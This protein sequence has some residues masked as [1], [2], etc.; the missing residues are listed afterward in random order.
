MYYYNQKGEKAK[1]IKNKFVNQ[2]NKPIDGLT[3]NYI[4]TSEFQTYLNFVP[5]IYNYTTKEFYYIKFND[6][7]KLLK[8]YIVNYDDLNVTEIKKQY[9]KLLE[10]IF[11]SNTGDNL[12]EIAKYVYYNDEEDMFIRIYELSS[13]LN[14]KKNIASPNLSFIHHGGM[15]SLNPDFHFFDDFFKVEGLK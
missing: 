14:K 5:V 6:F 2:S 13:W 8:I 11:S 10:K 7:M 4:Y 1:F 12:S 15:E 9:N 3:Y